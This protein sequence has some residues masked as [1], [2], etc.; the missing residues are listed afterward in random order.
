M[1][2]NTGIQILPFRTGSNGDRKKF[3]V[4]VIDVYRD[5]GNLYITIKDNFGST[6]DYYYNSY[7]R[8]FKVD[9]GRCDATEC[10]DIEEKMW[11][12]YNGNIKEFEKAWKKFLKEVTEVTKLF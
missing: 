12:E 10:F 7:E 5:N 9:G 6:C 8:L 4:N 1:K 11:K 3:K 2:V